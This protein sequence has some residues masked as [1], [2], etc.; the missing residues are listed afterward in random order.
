MIDVSIHASAREATAGAV[1]VHPPHGVS[2]HAS[3]REATVSLLYARSIA[4]VSIHASAREAT[5]APA[6]IDASSR[7]FD[8][9]LRAGGDSSVT[10]VAGGAAWFRSTPPRGRRRQRHGGQR[11][12]RAVSIHASAREATCHDL[13]GDRRDRVSIHASAREATC[14]RW[15]CA[16]WPGCF[17]PRLR[18]GGDGEAVRAYLT[19]KEF[20]STP[21]RGRRP[22]S[23]PLR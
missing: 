18:A 3:A 21:P 8:P 15:T 23:A 7:G 4:A 12:N 13:H 10:K 19:A 11:H 14:A 16:S 9:R 20:R 6:L 1:Q 5:A 2:I 22:P 17:D